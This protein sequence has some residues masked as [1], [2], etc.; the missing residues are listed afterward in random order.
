M[1]IGYILQTF[2]WSPNM[3]QRL[4]RFFPGIHSKDFL[5]FWMICTVSKQKWNREH[6]VETDPK[7]LS[8]YPVP[9]PIPQTHYSQN[10]PQE[11]FKKF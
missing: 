3:I 8:F 1:G 11:F 7:V 5:K 6:F 4:A 10:P 2:I 9:G